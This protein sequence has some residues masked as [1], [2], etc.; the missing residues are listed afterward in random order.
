MKSIIK[1]K[2]LLFSFT[3]ILIISFYVSNNGCSA[4]F[5]HCSQ[6]KPNTFEYGFSDR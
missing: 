6:F 3:K 1:T 5:Y 2:T 4:Q